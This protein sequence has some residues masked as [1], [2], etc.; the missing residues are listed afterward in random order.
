MSDAF[1]E[2]LRLFNAMP[3]DIFTSEYRVYYNKETGE[4]LKSIPTERNVEPPLGDYIVITMDQ[5]PPRHLARVQDQK[6]VYPRSNKRSYNLALADN[7]YGT[8]K[9]NPYVIG[10]EQFYEYKIR[11]E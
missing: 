4:I 3:K 10:D 11:Y 2:G 7:G 8:K 6:L 1:W 5:Y 9:N